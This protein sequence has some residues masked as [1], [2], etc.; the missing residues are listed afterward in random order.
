MIV[1]IIAKMKTSLKQL[2]HAI[3]KLFFP[4]KNQTDS[5]VKRGY[6]KIFHIFTELLKKL[7][8]SLALFTC[9]SSFNTKIETIIH[10]NKKIYTKIL[11]E[12]HM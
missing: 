1:F 5:Y 12:L 9:S 8:H 4:F 7:L 6:N 2:R 3:N 11:T 10:E